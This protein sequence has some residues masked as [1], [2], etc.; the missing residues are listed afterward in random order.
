LQQCTAGDICADIGNHLIEK[1]NKPWDIA[2]KVHY[3]AQSYQGQLAGKFPDHKAW[4]TP[5]ADRKMVLLML[6]SG[7]SVINLLV[8]CCNPC[9]ASSNPVV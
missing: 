1:L 9:K 7:D 8:R 5:L 2:H 3:T 6:I 4:W